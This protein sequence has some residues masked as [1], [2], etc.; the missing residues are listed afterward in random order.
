MP[1]KTDHLESD[2][3]RS[4]YSAVE[5]PELSGLFS[6]LA[7]EHREFA[8]LMGRVAN[9][10]DSGHRRQL[11]KELRRQLLAHELGELKEVY[12]LLTGYKATRH[13][14]TIHAD[15][16]TE[17][18]ITIEHLDTLNV[19]HEQWESGLRHLMRLFHEHIEQ[20]EIVFFPSAQ[21]VLGEA[22]SAELQT[23]YEAAKLSALKRLG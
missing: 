14:A 10:E 7:Q 23:R 1:N 12:P 9:T 3:F 16:S 13:L 15:E 11:Y 22:E 18:D 17:L 21:D 20:E 4:R 8:K 19:D 6:L 2:V 5:V